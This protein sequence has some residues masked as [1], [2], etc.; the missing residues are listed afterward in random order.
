[1]KF[2]NSIAALASPLSI[3]HLTTTASPLQWNLL[4]MFRLIYVCLPSPR[5]PSPRVCKRLVS[6]LLEL[7]HS[8]C[9]TKARA[10]SIVFCVCVLEANGFGSQ[11]V[12]F[13]CRIESMT[14]SFVSGKFEWVWL[15]LQKLSFCLFV[16]MFR[17]LLRRRPFITDQ[18]GMM[19]M[20]EACFVFLVLPGL[21]KFIAA[22]K[23]YFQQMNLFNHLPGMLATRR[24]PVFS[25][26]N[27]SWGSV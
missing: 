26:L 22:F 20:I 11:I 9:T 14:I 24:Q 23:H 3:H 16:E 19:V 17:L 5:L 15:G 12:L 25:K 18:W 2:P 8:A 7:H 6:V 1:M 13:W 27:I 21:R 10:V 4:F